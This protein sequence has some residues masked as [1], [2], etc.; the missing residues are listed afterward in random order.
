LRDNATI[1]LLS[2]NVPNPFRGLLPNSTSL[3]GSTVALSQLLVPFPQYPAGSGT[4]NGVI[5]QGNYGGKSYF[6]SLNVRLQKRL[7]QGLTVINNFIWSK[8]IERT[9]YLNDSDPAPEKRVGANSRPFRELLAASYELP[10]GRGKRLNI[11]SRLGN[12]LA[13]GWALNGTMTLQSGPPLSWGNVI[14]YGGPLALQGHQP[15][16]LAFDITR[17]NTVS[18]QQ[19]ASNIRTFNTLFNNLRRD[20]T[21]NLDLSVLKKFSLGERRYFQLRFESFNTTNHVTFGAPNL[22]P[23]SSTFGMITAQANTPRRLQVG[24]RLVW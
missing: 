7:T 2:G 14:Y 23:T 10:V 1:N 19:L 20:P 18:S 13:G 15:D 16:G 22:T 12:A 4:T 9:A 11:R 8:L 17:F 5:M 21:K 3:N 24:A 6:H